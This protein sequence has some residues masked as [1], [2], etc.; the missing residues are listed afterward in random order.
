MPVSHHQGKEWLERRYAEVRPSSVVDLGAGEGIYSMRL[1][2]LW[3]SHWTALEGFEPYVNRFD[4]RAKYDRIDVA[5]I[6]SAA[7]EPADL[8]IAGDVLEHMTRAEALEVIE[9]MKAVAGHIF[10]SVPII[11]ICQGAVN[12]N[13]LE[14]HVHHWTFDDMHSAL[15]GCDSFRGSVIGA[16][17]W[18]R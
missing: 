8:Y 14:E 18:S 11:E 3:R 4:L 2:P 6:R 1:R 7:F 9:R 16:F 12:G 5:D 17:H 15:D 13:P 10:V